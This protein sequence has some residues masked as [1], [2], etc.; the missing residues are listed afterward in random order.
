MTPSHVQTIQLVRKA[1]GTAKQTVLKANA[2]P[3]LKS[4]LYYTYNPFLK[5]FIQKINTKGKG[6]KE[7]RDESFVILDYLASR[8]LSGD[9]AK[10]TVNVHINALDPA[11]AELFKCILKKDLRMGM[12]AATINKVFPDL[13]PTFGVM[14]ATT[15]SDKLWR[16][17]M[18]G[19]LKLDGLR[20]YWNGENLLT[21]NGHIIHG[22][23]HIT[24]YLGH[25]HLD[26]ELMDPTAHFQKSS[27]DT[28]SFNAA[29]NIQYFV[30]DAPKINLGFRDR[31]NW[32]T[33]YCTVFKATE[34]PISIVKHIIMKSKED[35]ER[36]FEKSLAAGYEGL[37]LK[38]PS[39]L[40]QE[41]RSKDWLKV[42]N[43]KSEDLPIIGFYE[44][45]GRLEGTLGGI[46]VMRKNG[47]PV[48]VGSGFSDALRM[49]IWNT[50]DKW[51][52]TIHEISYHEETPDGSL[53]HPVY[54]KRRTD[55]E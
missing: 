55:K 26:G 5:F 1:S 32:L 12:A 52:D 50:R 51:T 4:I 10:Q 46:V 3:L 31:Y 21:R 18:Y 8:K 27:G 22:M 35:V 45:E 23:E 30:F 20:G 6:F 49:E 42:K 13:I 34:A 43:S 47:V 37:V 11:E 16:P 9:Y 14:R 54:G 41:K 17:G 40:Y 29:P 28:R 38:N 53:R 39:S 36:N 2:T 19:S 7:I 44:G 48:K 25:Y 24:N 33:E 15:I